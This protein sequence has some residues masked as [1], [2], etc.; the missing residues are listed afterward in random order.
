MNALITRPWSNAIPGVLPTTFFTS[1]GVILSARGV[2]ECR[3]TVLKGRERVHYK[4]CA[5]SS[6]SLLF[7]T[8]IVSPSVEIG[9]PPTTGPG[10]EDQRSSPLPAFRPHPDPRRKSP[11]PVTT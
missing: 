5:S 10:T 4:P 11:G 3:S 2:Q 1:S 9:T 6:Q 7:P 8:L